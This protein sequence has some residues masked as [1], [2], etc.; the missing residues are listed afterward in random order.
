MKVS[1]IIHSTNAIIVTLCNKIIIRIP[2][3][4]IKDENTSHLHFHKTYDHNTWQTGGLSW[5]ATT[6]KV[7]LLCN[8]VATWSHVKNKKRYTSTSL[9]AMTAKLGKVEI[10]NKG[11]PSLK[12]FDALI[13]W[14]SD[15]VTDKTTSTRTMAK[16]LDIVV[17][18]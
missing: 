12:S 3:S 9:M 17:G 7:T 16:K 10:Y 6:N 4:Y 5:E 14:S 2:S 15:H 18:F 8:H 13:T 1:R 11:P